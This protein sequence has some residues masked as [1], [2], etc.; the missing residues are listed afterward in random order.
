MMGN[1]RTKPAMLVM[2]LTVLVMLIMACGGPAATRTPITTATAVSVP[3]STGLP[4][5]V[6]QARGGALYVDI[7]EASGGTAHWDAERNGVVLTP[8]GWTKT[9]RHLAVCCEGRVGLA[10]DGELALEQPPVRLGQ[11]ITPGDGVAGFLVAAW[12]VE[13]G[14][15]EAAVFLDTDWEEVVGEQVF[16][17]TLGLAQDGSP[18]SSRAPVDFSEAVDGVYMRSFRF[19]PRS[20]EPGTAPIVAAS[21]VEGP[22]RE[23]VQSVNRMELGPSD[24]YAHAMGLK[25]NRRSQPESD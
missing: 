5:Y 4:P 19:S 1:A 13:A 11:R 16:L 8:Q 10:G 14:R 7:A 24:V 9:M 22:P 2:A 25:A 15:L 18:T 20:F 23:V 3:E 17:Y 6:L 21:N 12:P